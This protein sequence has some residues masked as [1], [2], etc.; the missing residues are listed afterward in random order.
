VRR[1]REEW[2]RERRRPRPGGRRLRDPDTRERIL[3]VARQ[4][5][6]ESGFRQVTVRDISREASAN[7]AA[8]SYY[9]GDKLG[10]YKE[11]VDEAIG[12]VSGADATIR[13]PEG[14]SPEERIRHY[15]RTYVPAVATAEARGVLITRL[16]RHEMDEPTQLAPWIAERIIMPRIQY[17]ATAIAELLGCQ[18]TDPRVGRCVVSIQSQC[19]FFLPNR[20]RKAA[21]PD[22]REDI[23]HM[24]EHIA[25][26]S[27][28][29]IRALAGQ[30]EKS[31]DGA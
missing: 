3:R 4:L 29:G 11:V 14:S 24:A 22:W 5:F 28:A 12:A 9:F 10:L 13:A 31:R 8:V 16:M 25:G 21:F 27:L 1:L 18:V 23:I 20:F 19:L 6:A 7:L 17:L 15:I 26:F 30:A 2:R